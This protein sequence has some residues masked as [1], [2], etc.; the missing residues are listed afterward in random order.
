MP[1]QLGTKFT[2]NTP[3]T[4]SKAKEI[5]TT[6]AK[7]D[8]KT[9][10]YNSGSF[11]VEFRDGTMGTIPIS[12]FPELSTA[13]EADFQEL[14]VSPAGLMIETENVE[15]DCAEFGLYQIATQATLPVQ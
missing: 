13:T 3:R 11:Q 2:D 7:W 10:Q 1:G 5:P 9:A 6:Q 8:I 15:W 14:D 12:E 4:M